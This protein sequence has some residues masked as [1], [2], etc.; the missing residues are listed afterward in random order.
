[1]SLKKNVFFVFLLSLLINFLTIKSVFSSRLQTRPLTIMIDPVGDAKHTGRIIDDTFERGLTLQCAEQI[2]KEL[3]NNQEKIRVVLTR[4]PGETLEPLQNANFANRLG[5]DIYI[6]ISFYQEKEEKSRVYFYHYISYKTD[7]WQKKISDLKL[8]SYDKAHLPYINSSLKF[9]QSFEKILNN[10]KNRALFS[11]KGFFG[12]PFKTL[13]GI[14]APAIAIEMGL[15][16][17]DD[18]K[19]FVNPIIYA[20]ESTLDIK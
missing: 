18:W 10:K 14:K 8:Y 3:E 5:C 15:I 12:L 11:Y 4:F 9:G 16:K 17:K 13:A 6:S 2:K 19:M 1:M 7:I 20:I